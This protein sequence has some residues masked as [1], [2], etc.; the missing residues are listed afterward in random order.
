MR[1]D[2]LL[3]MI[4]HENPDIVMLQETKVQDADFPKEYFEDLG[5]NIAISGQ[6]SYNGVAI[7]SKDILE[8]ANY[9][10]ENFE[11]ESKRYIDCFTYGMRVICVYVPNGKDILHN[12]YDYKL[13]FFDALKKDVSKKIDTD[14]KIIIAGDFNVALKDD[15]VYD[16]EKWR[17][18]ILFSDVEKQK[19]NSILS[20]GFFDALKNEGF[21]WWDYRG[22]SFSK[23]HGAR[24][25]YVLLSPA[26]S[27]SFSQ[28]KVLKHVREKEKPSD[29]APLCCII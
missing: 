24:I 16:A 9:K 11:D 15:D 21:T 26:L 7:F 6:K 19:M 12:D 18:R 20:L 23:D 8:D 27:N 5:Y 22:G 13:S 4:K 10:I 3:D 17:N 25:D 28:S 2:M 14:E 1:K 29:H